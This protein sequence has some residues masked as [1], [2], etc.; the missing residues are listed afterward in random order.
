MSLDT[1]GCCSK[2]WKSH[3]IGGAARRIK[4][5]IKMALIDV[6]LEKRVYFKSTVWLQGVLLSV[7]STTG[8][9]HNS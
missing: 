9:A 7:E 3:L 4:E 5:E 1:N 6:Y 2:V 8:L